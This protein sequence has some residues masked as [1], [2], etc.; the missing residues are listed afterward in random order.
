MVFDVSVQNPK[1]LDKKNIGFVE[2]SS[3]DIDSLIRKISNSN[4][5]GRSVNR[6]DGK[7]AFINI[8]IRQEKQPKE[9]YQRVR[10]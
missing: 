3:V 9:A 8:I 6:D 10:W 7:E 1:P 5:M 4:R 2:L